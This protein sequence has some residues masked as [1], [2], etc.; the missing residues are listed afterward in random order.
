MEFV[1]LNSPLASSGGVAG[2][3]F[4]LRKKYPATTMT[5][6]RARLAGSA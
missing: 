1:H 2:P 4:F 5:A 3:G 6:M